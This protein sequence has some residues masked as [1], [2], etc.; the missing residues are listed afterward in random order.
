[1]SLLNTIEPDQAEG[2]VAETYQDI[3]KMIGFVPNALRMYSTN[4]VMLRQ[5]WAG[6]SYYFQ[7]PTL[8]GSLFACIRLLVSVTQRCEYCITLNTGMLMNQFGVKPEQIEAMKQNPEG[9]PIDDKEKALLVFV[10]RSV[11][12]SNGTT[13]A[14]IQSL[15]DTGCTDQ[16]IFDALSHG[17]QQVA[18]DIMLNAL[19]VENDF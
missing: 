12:D 3:S 8:S 2:A 6:I 7:H 10:L 5:R 18:G 15:R 16:E 4:P 11:A 9:A 13:A 17:A 19:K 14:E 1:M